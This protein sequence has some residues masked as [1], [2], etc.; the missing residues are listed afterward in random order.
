MP[1]ST[2]TRRRPGS[3]RTGFTL[4]E[5]IGTMVLLGAAM[6]LTLPL[7]RT[8]NLQR[9]AADRRLIA[10]QESA[11]LMERFSAREWNDVTQAAA[12]GLALSN[13]GKR[14]LPD[15]VLKVTVESTASEPQ[16]K[17]IRIELRWKNAHG[18]LVAPVRLTAVV[19]R[20]EE[21]K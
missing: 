17:R 18:D 1:V 12:D 11:N 3:R 9:R 8:V 5:L 7:L 13:D 20:I 16:G 21:P 6:A 15:S 14:T 19:Y 4:I 2:A 10:V